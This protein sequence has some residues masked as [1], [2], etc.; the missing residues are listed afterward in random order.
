MLALP[1][2][3]PALPTAEHAGPPQ[4]DSTP[5]RP[6][7][8]RR[9]WRLALVIVLGGWALLLAAWLALHS[10]VLGQL[11]SWR[12]R[13]EA[14]INRQL[15][16]E[17]LTLRIA[18]LQAQTGQWVPVFTAQEV[19]LRNAQGE[20]VLHVPRLVAMVSAHS[21]L[22]AE[23]VFRQIVIESP[24][25]TAHRDAQGR[26]QVAG[27]A[28]HPEAQGG[29]PAA[30]WILSQPEIVVRAGQVR[31]QDDASGQPAAEL[32]GVDV[33]LRYG[34]HR[35]RWRL[36]A[37]P[38]LA[39]GQ[40]FGLRGDFTR[41]LLTRAGDVAQWQGRVYADAPLLDWAALV[42]H[43]HLP[44]TVGTGRGALRAW[45]SRAPGRWQA[46]TLDVA[47]ADVQG[48]AAGDLPPLRWQALQG[49][50]HL[51]RDGDRYQAATQAVQGVLQ[52]G[53]TWPVGNVTLRWRQRGDSAA[54]DVA[55][56]ADGELQVPSLALA[57]ATELALRLPLP[58]ALRQSL[59]DV[60]P[61]G[62]VSDFALRWQGRPDAPTDW[63]VGFTAS[64]LALQAERADDP[65]A[66]GRPGVRGLRAQ[67]QA[68][69][70]GGTA[71][72]QIENGSLTFPGVFAEPEIALTR[73]DAHLSWTATPA[74]DGGPP[75]IAL[76]VQGATFAN[77][78]AQGSLSG[79]WQTGANPGVGAG[80]R[81]P[82]RIDLEG[83]I[84]QGQGTQVVR[85]LPLHIPVDTRH[86][87]ATAVHSGQIENARF[88]VQGDLWDFPYAHGEPG[89]FRIAGRVRGLELAYVPPG[90]VDPEDAG[91]PPFT[92]VAGELVFDRARM[93]IKDASARLWG[94]ALSGVQ[95]EI[96]NLG[97]DAPEL[98][99]HGKGRGPATDAL[100]FLEATPIA[101]WM[102]HALGQ[103]QASGTA[104]LELALTIPLL[105][106][107]DTRLKGHI[108]LADNDLRLRPD[109]PLLEAASGEVA[110]T[111]RDFQVRQGQAT[112]LGGQA[113]FAGGSQPDGSLHFS[114]QGV[115]TAAGLAAETAWHDAAPAAR[116]LSGQAAYTLALTLRDGQSEVRVDSDLQGLAVDLPPPLHKPA[117][118]AWPLHIAS[119]LDA[120]ARHDTLEL[121]LADVVRA[122]Y[123][124]EL[125]S[126]PARVV[127]GGIAIGPGELPWPEQGVQAQIGLPQLD[128]DAWWA[129]LDSLH[130]QGAAAASAYEPTEAR[131]R[132][133]DLSLGG[134]H[135]PSQQVQARSA[136]AGQWLLTLDGPHAKGRVE[137]SA[138]RV[139]A[140]LERLVL[141]GVQDGEPLRREGS[142]NWPALD[143]VVDDLVWRD[144]PWGRLTLMARNLGRNW[145][146]E[147]LDLHGS[148]AALSATGRWEVGSRTEVAG[149]LTLTDAGRL[150]EHLGLGPLVRGGKGQ[151]KGELAW[152]GGP[153][154]LS[155]AQLTGS[156][157]LDVSS[158]QFLQAEPGAARLLGILNLQALPRRLALDFRDV[159][160]EGFTFDHIDGQ[161]QLA[162]GQARTRNLR[163]RGVQAIILV[164][165]EADL[166]RETQN[167]HVVIVPEINAG[168]AALA[169][170]AINPVLGLG[171]FAAQFL[172][173]K[174]L[175]DAN[176]RE[177]RVTGS[178]DEPQIETLNRKAEE[179]TP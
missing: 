126:G 160:A 69:H 175:Q 78:D 87:V 27:I 104:G 118:A 143:V 12:P 29:S 166:A 64:G 136:K 6:S 5:Q 99:V 81:L 71:Q 7:W 83:V 161:L 82:G 89:V 165:G 47:L 115:M 164:E 107:G 72:V 54:G 124:R 173:R 130:P 55:A 9:I 138:Q 86:Y 43:L 127:A 95:G 52:N 30:D 60:A 148:S 116:A 108:T 40:R 179:P 1:M 174:P 67:V 49:R 33:L 70:A 90:L 140:R 53:T 169:Y 168:T 65:K 137:A 51:Q 171:T 48:R 117:Q 14:A 20:V 26:W 75:A 163:V 146:V 105:N 50:L 119:R 11:D 121:T 128:A 24:R 8:A 39:W 17:G 19:T 102:G 145:L 13:I 21:L 177:L 170:A 88:A 3:L 37:T 73:A 157:E 15:A 96:P 156:L 101:G 109:V 135:W 141:Q 147:Q 133:A 22:R 79:R 106:A 59:Q 68:S 144:K 132:I 57:G 34:L 151:I 125:G 16:P 80:Q 172:L 77:A 178:W 28:L 94:V 38:P 153:T 36:D 162:D 10:L 2:S 58:A 113:H 134:L 122:R 120:D 62:Q 111:E 98:T 76:R 18:S 159:F 139:Q 92:D 91:W 32:T 114:G 93:Q 74:Q 46:M 112:V 56:I 45:L 129:R 85:Y 100:R 84:T 44:V 150:I 158:G 142:G 131:L 23:L 42:P 31:W 123:R 167:L 97:A 110:F 176:T 25:V 35:H 152:P 41:G 63:R 61:Q 149:T 4:L 154:D 66:L 103:A 155:R